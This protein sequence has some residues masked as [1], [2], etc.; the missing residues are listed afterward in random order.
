MCAMID[1]DLDYVAVDLD[2]IWLIIQ[3]QTELQ[4]DNIHIK[5]QRMLL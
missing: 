3:G 4:F 1:L 5:S 2:V